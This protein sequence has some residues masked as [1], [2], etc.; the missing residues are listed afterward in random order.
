MG[1]SSSFIF[2]YFIH[3]GMKTKR[4]RCKERKKEKI[5]HV[6]EYVKTGGNININNWSRR[7]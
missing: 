4:I 6:D 3:R 2:I 5:V 1:I 7:I